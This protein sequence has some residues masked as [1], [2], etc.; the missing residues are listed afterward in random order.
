MLDEGSNDKDWNLI[1]TKHLFEFANQKTDEQKLLIENQTQ[2]V[3]KD[4]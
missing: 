2:D 4:Y 3:F 1:L